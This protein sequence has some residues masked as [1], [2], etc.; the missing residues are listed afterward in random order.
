MYI[1]FFILFLLL[2]NAILFAQTGPG[3]VGNSSSN[4]LWLRSDAISGLVNGDTIS[5]W[6]DVSGNNNTL[7]QSNIN[8]RPKYVTSAVNGFPVV[9]FNVAGNRLIRNPFNGFATNDITAIYVNKNN[10]S[11]DGIISY[12]PSSAL[13][14]D[15]LLYGSQNIGFYRN[16]NINT[17]VSVNN[18]NWH[19]VQSS[20]GSVGG[21]AEI[22]KDGKKD[23][24]T[25]GF[26]SGTSITSGGSLCLAHEQDSPDGGYASNQDHI[27]DFTEVIIYNTYLDSAD[28]M[29]MANYLSA[30]YNITL[31]ANDFY[32]EDNT[33]NGDFDFEVAGIGMH[34]ATAAHTDAQGSAI[35]RINNPNDLEIG[36]YMMWGHNGANSAAT[37]VSDIPSGV[38]ARYERVWRVSEVN[39]SGNTTDVGSVDVAWDLS[40]S[41]PASASHLRLLVDTDNDG[42]FNDETPISGAVLLTGSGANYTFVGVTELADN[43]RFTLATTNTY[44]T[45]LPISLLEFVGTPLQNSSNKLTWEAASE[46][47]NDFYTLA[48]SEDN[49]N[50]GEIANISGAGNSNQ[51]TQY[52]FLDD[53][54]LNEIT[55]YRLSQTD[56]DGRITTL[57]TISVLNQ[58]A[59][60]ATHLLYPNPTNG[61]FRIKS[62]NLNYTNIKVMS[63]Q[64]NAI[65]FSMSII[66][67][68]EVEID[69]SK[70][71]QGTY[72]IQIGD[73]TYKIIYQ[74]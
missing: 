2:F 38:Q 6:E 63:A 29:I 22:W 32:D 33:A 50:W 11:S 25:T 42:Y 67:S 49:E 36:E 15:F 64:G 65:K 54:P 27:G 5:S 73:I 56:F 21:R 70:E 9:S 66:N 40:S 14:N 19:I 17:G 43:L 61:M 45:P 26:V 28:H 44:A 1:K 46:V 18:N 68:N 24:N 4:I 52:Q 55:Y 39:T 10:A 62:D 41:W 71:P 74:K 16:S 60:F 53:N 7:S 12:A 34:S 8:L 47:N 3:G 51:K 48:S 23:F 72:F 69:I 59:K 20:W 13:N 31:T 58:A 35:L 37:N 30:K 57:N